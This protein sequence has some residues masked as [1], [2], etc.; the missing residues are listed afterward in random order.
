[1]AFSFHK[2]RGEYSRRHFYSEI[3]SA[4]VRD[5]VFILKLPPRLIF[6]EFL[7]YKRRGDCSRRHF[8]TETTSA[9]IRHAIFILK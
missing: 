4:I 2:R 1:M 9:I 5:A 7:F 8:Q 3:T 6:V